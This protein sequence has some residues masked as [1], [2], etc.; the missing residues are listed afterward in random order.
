MPEGVVRRRVG[1]EG[2]AEAWRKEVRRLV[3]RRGGFDWDIG[4]SGVDSL[5]VENGA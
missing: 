1:M 5:V 3:R 4:G 2:E